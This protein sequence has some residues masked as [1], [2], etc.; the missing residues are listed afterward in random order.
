MQ[1]WVEIKMTK[2]SK[3]NFI[4]KDALEYVAYGLASVFVLWLFDF[5][6]LSL[7]VL[8]ATL[9]YAYIFRQPDIFFNYAKEKSVLAPVE[10]QIVAITPL[11]DALFGYEVK[12][13]G[14]SKTESILR[15]PLQ[16]ATVKECSITNGTRLS[17]KS[18]LFTLLNE[19]ATVMFQDKEGNSVF[20][21]HRLKQ[22]I[23]GV[24]LE[25]KEGST[26]EQSDVYGVAFNA[27]TTLYL[28]HNFHFEVQSGD[29]VYCAQTILG[30]FE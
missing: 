29:D 16:N 25:V 8:A 2:N 10:G 19:Y 28:P 5:E 9:V 22:S 30:Y 14:T 6:F 17:R 11:E 4:Y 27:V 13:E 26:R 3:F 15:V 23:V 20:I 12:I 18:K 1:Q 21:N 24:S 7:V